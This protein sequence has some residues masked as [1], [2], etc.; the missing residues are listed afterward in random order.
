MNKASLRK[1]RLSLHVLLVSF[2]TGTLV[3]CGMDDDAVRCA[4]TDNTAQPVT[5]HIGAQQLPAQSADE[6]AKA[7]E[8]IHSLWVF[9]VDSDN[10]VE[11][12]LFVRSL[13]DV[14]DYHSQPVDNITTGAKTLY[15]FANFDV[16]IDEADKELYNKDLHDLLML[17]EG[18]KFISPDGITVADPAA[19]IDFSAG[20]H[21]PMSGKAKVTVTD[22]TTGISV[23]MD[24][25][26][27]KVRISIAAGAGKAG[28]VTF[29]GTSRMVS[30]M[31]GGAV[32]DAGVAAD[33]TVPFADNTSGIVI[34][35]FYVNATESSAGKG[36]T[37]V[38][39]GTDAE[40]NKVTY[41]A[42]TQRDRQPRNSIYPINLKFPDFG[43][44]LHADA[45]L[46]PIGG[47][48]PVVDKDAD[49]YHVELPQGCLW[50]FTFSGTGVENLAVKWPEKGD[51]GDYSITESGNNSMSGALSSGAAVGSKLSFGFDVT[52]T[53]PSGSDKGSYSRTYILEVTVKD[54]WDFLPAPARILPSETLGM[55]KIK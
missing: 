55:F 27:S 16:Y 18:D 46:A 35:D 3:S 38:L 17:K 51:Y 40:G 50:A 49:T 37:V 36:F 30:L 4:E 8:N 5:M 42:V 24:R 23:G 19:S 6:D 7:G 48:Q 26:V 9:L 20:R 25:L 2:C 11:W 14:T 52:F 22:N 41:R 39:N 29:G 10:K 13:D 32:S 47:L 33:R 28:S 12:K 21:I 44:I 31:S 43:F 45:W 53:V 54:I 1:L 15:A 34:P